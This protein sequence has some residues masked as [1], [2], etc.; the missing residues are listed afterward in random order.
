MRVHVN[1]NSSV[2]GD[3]SLEAHVEEVVLNVLARF[4]EDVTRVEVH[5]T[6]ENSHKG[7]TDDKRC[8]MEARIEGL[9]PVAVTHNA[10]TVK[11]SVSGAATKMR[12]AL[13]TTLGRAKRH[14]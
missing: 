7:G 12:N 5:I 11:E 10:G 14:R 6:D 9:N 13:S 4:K 1:T 3:E 8:M 2:E